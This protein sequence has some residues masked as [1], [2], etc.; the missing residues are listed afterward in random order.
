VPQLKV[1]PGYAP[2]RGSAGALV[3]STIDVASATILI[4]VGL[5]VGAVLIGVGIAGLV[6]AV[7]DAAWLVVI[8]TPMAVVAVHRFYLMR[9]RNGPPGDRKPIG[10]RA[11]AAQA[12]AAY[13][14]SAR[15][16]DT[17]KHTGGTIAM[18]PQ[19]AAHRPAR[20]P[21]A[22]AMSARSTEATRRN[23]TANHKIEVHSAA[24]NQSHEPSAQAVTKQTKRVTGASNRARPVG[25]VSAAGP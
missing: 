18:P 24:E 6:A 3:R 15:G 16:S 1:T 23:G 5:V 11:T 2:V 4:F 21:S 12:A 7:P 9:R 25:S 19:T 20:P 22:P 8:G 14:K 10:Y 13:V 17:T